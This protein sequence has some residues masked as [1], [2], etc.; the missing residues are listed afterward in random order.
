MSEPVPFVDLK[1]QYLS[2]KDEV[3]RAVLDLLAVATEDREHRDLSPVRGLR[4]IVDVVV[5]ARGAIRPTPT[6]TSL[7]SVS[8]TRLSGKCSTASAA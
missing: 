5:V 7:A 4:A 8:T 1:A 2:I 3:D 6:A